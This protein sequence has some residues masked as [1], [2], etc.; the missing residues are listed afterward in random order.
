MRL[1]IELPPEPSE[2]KASSIPFDAVA[3]NNTPAA[4]RPNM[5]KT[6]RLPTGLP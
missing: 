1:A 3:P 6:T 5:P 2:D 4:P